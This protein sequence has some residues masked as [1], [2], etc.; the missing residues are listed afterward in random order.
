MS[1]HGDEY[2]D[3]VWMA[4]ESSIAEILAD[5]TKETG[6]P[7]VGVSVLDYGDGRY[8]VGIETE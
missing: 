5:F 7:V 6:K 8:Q 4:A 2:V 1:R 3:T